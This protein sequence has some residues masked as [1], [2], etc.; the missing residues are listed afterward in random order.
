MNEPKPP[1]GRIVREADETVPESKRCHLCGSS[2]QKD[3]F[4]VAGCI[5]PVCPNYYKKG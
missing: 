1:V 4:K 5:Q 3:F 2:L